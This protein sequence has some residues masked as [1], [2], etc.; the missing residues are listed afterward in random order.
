MAKK[1]LLPLV[2]ICGRPNVGKSTLF[3]RIIG[4][5]S[6]IVHSEEGITRDRAYGTAEWG[7]R[8][9]RVVDTG[10]IVENP[11]DPILR[12]IQEQVRI[13][14]DEAAV[15]LFVVDGRQEITRVD[16]ELRDELFRHSKPVVLAANK[17]DNP[18][19]ELYR[20]EFYALGMGE[21]YAISS[22]HG[23]GIGEL[24][25]AVVARFPESGS[26][27]ES[28]PQEAP[29]TRVAVIGKP[30]VGKSSFINAILNQERQIVNE[31]PGTTRDA[32]DLDFLWHGTRYVLID[33]AGMRKKAG[34]KRPVEFFSVS[35]ALRAVR[36]ADV[37]LVLVDAVDGV[38]EQDKRILGYV[39][40]QGASM[41]LVLTKWD[42]VEDKKARF[43]A[44]SEEL[45]FKAPFVK[46]VPFMTVSNLTRQ[47][48]FKT[49]DVIDRVAAEAQKRI[50]TADLNKL[51]QEL[52][53][54]TAPATYKG[55]QAKILYATQASVSPPPLSFS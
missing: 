32:I 34:I 48:L 5:Q 36:R 22:G 27:A 45:E 29:A 37:C 49:F 14:L 47:R 16:Q 21:P 54:N 18:T 19:L 46:Y 23:L 1:H 24:L 26:A 9:F 3:N 39:E 51:V 43:K 30:N 53:A 52:Q 55:K 17:L 33:T 38:T 40:E 4:K 50:S 12:K 44:L 25:D 41:I 15:I 13:A 6:A 28:E 31:V 20:H 11:I 7:G 35:R 2:A 42:L 8:R 10:G